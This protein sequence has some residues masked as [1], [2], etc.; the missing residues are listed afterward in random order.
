MKVERLAGE[1]I[2]GALEDLARLRT[3]VFRAFPYL[4]DGDPAN[5]HHYLRSYRE[6]P[7]AVLVVARDGDRVVG[8]ATGMPLADHGD[9]ADLTGP[10]P[11]AEQVFYCA[12]SVLLPQYRGRGIGHQFFDLREAEARRQGFDYALFCAVVRPEDHPARP[13]DYRPLDR[14]WRKR[15]YAPLDGVEAVFHWTDL[16]MSSPT[17]HRLSA[18]MRRL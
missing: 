3:E 12:E 1:Q 4:Y 18:W 16:G 15:G 9:A 13:S 11:P 5:E 8:A 10:T 17:P 2:D 14:F 6:N 7:N